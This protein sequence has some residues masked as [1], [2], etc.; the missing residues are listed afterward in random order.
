[1]DAGAREGCLCQII[2][3]LLIAPKNQHLRPP[4]GEHMTDFKNSFKK[5]VCLEFL[6]S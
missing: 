4:L 2:A 5:V 1:M 3:N 6:F